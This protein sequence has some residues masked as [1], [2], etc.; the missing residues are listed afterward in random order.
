M[1]CQVQEA[2]VSHLKL[3]ARSDA[4][5]MQHARLLARRPHAEAVTL[6]RWAEW[7]HA[8]EVAEPLPQ[9]LR[10]LRVDLRDKAADAA[11]DS[12]PQG[13]RSL[14]LGEFAIPNS[15]YPINRR[16]DAT[17]RQAQGF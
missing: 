14:L 7:E 1:S 13:L 12:Q 3:L 5:A 17:P 16:E 8:Q 10:L 15:F 2:P 9:G 11:I 4:E 6:L